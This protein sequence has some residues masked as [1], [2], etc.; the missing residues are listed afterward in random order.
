MILQKLNTMKRPIIG[1]CQMFQSRIVGVKYLNRCMLRRSGSYVLCV[2]CHNI[3]AA[4]M[5][6]NPFVHSESIQSTPE[7]YHGPCQPTVQ[8]SAPFILPKVAR[9]VAQKAQNATRC[10]FGL[11]LWRVVIHPMLLRPSTKQL[12]S[13][14]KHNRNRGME[15]CDWIPSDF[16]S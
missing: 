14:C 7:V 8:N 11:W 15:S 5:T 9:A 10:A 12:R 6:G 13:C 1:L 2:V 3:W 16:E 4:L